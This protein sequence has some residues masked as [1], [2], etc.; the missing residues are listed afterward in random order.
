VTRRSQRTHAPTAMRCAQ[1]LPPLRGSNNSARGG[2]T[3]AVKFDSR[4][5]A[6]MV[7]LASAC[8]D[9]GVTET[10]T[11]AR[12]AKTLGA[13][14]L[15]PSGVSGRQRITIPAR[16]RSDRA[17]SGVRLMASEIP[18]PGFAVRIRCHPLTSPAAADPAHRSI[19]NPPIA[20]GKNIGF[21]TMD[22]AGSR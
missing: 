19:N 6:T 15:E 20:I 11:T 9:S 17:A 1:G 16:S 18:P 10:I 21:F 8:G 12:P 14:P 5:S 22:R 3:C 7:T 4:P 13:P 2:R